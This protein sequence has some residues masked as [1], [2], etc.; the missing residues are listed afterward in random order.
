M[1]SMDRASDRQSKGTRY[2]WLVRRMDDALDHGYFLEAISVAHAV[3][4]D[5]LESVLHEMGVTPQRSLY[6]RLDTVLRLTHEREEIRDAFSGD[7]LNRIDQWRTRRNKVMH[8]LAAEES[9]GGDLEA[10]AHEGASLAREAA[11]AV[12][13]LKR[14]VRHGRRNASPE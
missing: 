6:A 14:R 4:E 3:L 7:L 8:T 12:M 13:R 5:R 2:R 1:T 9:V 10:A 11:S